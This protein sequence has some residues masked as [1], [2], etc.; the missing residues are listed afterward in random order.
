MDSDNISKLFDAYYFA[1][2]C[3]TPYGRS[4]EWLA[5][6]NSIADGIVKHIQPKTVLDAGCAMGLLVEALRQR[7][8]EAYG[9]D[10][11][12]Y[13]IQNLPPSV[14]KYCWL[15]SVTDALPEQYDLIV[16]IE[17]LEHMPS[18]DAEKAIDNFCQHSNDILF[19]STPITNNWTRRISLSSRKKILPP[20]FLIFFLNI[21]F[22]SS[23]K[24]RF[25]NYGEC[26]EFEASAD[27]QQRHDRYEHGRYRHSKLGNRPRSGRSM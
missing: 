5:L 11:S 14:Q 21:N 6:F 2:G 9:V 18:T 4:D 8:V 3:G 23:L 7:S 17:V 10:I 19:S 16:S 25:R 13:A 1:H 12:E 15:G 24:N 27:R 20:R 26:S 22:R